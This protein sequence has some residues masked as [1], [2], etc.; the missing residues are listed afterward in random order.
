MENKQVLIINGHPDQESF[1]NALAAAYQKGAETSDAVVSLLNIRE[2]YFNPNLEFGYRKRIN[3]EPDLLSSIE[4]IKAADHL[5]WVFPM[6]WYG[7]PALMKGF[8]DRTFLPGI[9][10]DYEPGKTVSKKLL[11]GK[12]ARIIMTADTPKLYDRLFMKSPAL[13]QFKKGTL[14]FCGVNPVKVSYI[15]PIKSS[16]EEFR[17]KYLSKIEQLGKNNK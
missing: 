2:L 11:K 3:L 9:M 8:I 10:F 1:N 17:K 6:W 12:T 4:K 5:V 15:A 16:S 13:N 7:Y 14:Q